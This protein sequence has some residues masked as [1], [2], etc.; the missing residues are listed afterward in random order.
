MCFGEVVFASTQIKRAEF[1]IDVFRLSGQRG[2][3]LVTSDGAGVIALED[4][5]VGDRLVELCGLIA[6]G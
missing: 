2:R 6:E 3:R 4:L 1:A 5:D